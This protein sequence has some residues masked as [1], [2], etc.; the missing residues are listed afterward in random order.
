MLH[1]FIKNAIHGNDN[2]TK[3]RSSIIIN[4]SDFYTNKAPGIQY[5]LDNQNGNDD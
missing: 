3:S 4:I 2:K 5:I 1:D